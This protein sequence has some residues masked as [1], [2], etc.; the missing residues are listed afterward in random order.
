LQLKIETTQAAELGFAPE[1]D[2]RNEVTVSGLVPGG[3]A[4]AAGL[5][6]GDLISLARTRLSPPDLLAWLRGRSA[7]DP[8][9]LRVRRDGNETEVSFLVG[10][11]EDREFSIAEIPHPSPQQ[12]DIREGIL[13]GSSSP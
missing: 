10:S 3:A 6:G 4:E 1:I 2:S 11:R 5:R 9:T 12:R 7:G 13:R 8:L